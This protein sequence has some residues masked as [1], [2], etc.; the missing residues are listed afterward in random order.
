M[1]RSLLVPLDGSDLSEWSLPLATK[2]ARAT[3]AQLHLARVHERYEPEHLIGNSSFQWEGLDLEEYDG[4]HRI[5]ESEYLTTV[6]ERLDGDGVVVDARLLDGDPAERLA[7]YADE[8]HS[9]LIVITSHGR[10]GLRRA[11]LGSVTDAIIRTTH[12]PLLILHPGE[13][14]ALEAGNLEI[15]HI[16]VPLDGS[17][18]SE[19]VLGPARDLARAA[20]AQITL[21]HVISDPAVFGPRIMTFRPDRVGAELDRVLSYLEDLAEELRDAGVDTTVYANKGNRPAS[22]IAHMARELDAD[23]IALA[24][25]GYGG[26]KRTV[27]G[28]VTDKLL[29]TTHVPLLVVRPPITA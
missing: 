10:S 11:W 22:A 5:H 25:H 6:T 16:V 26:M 18:A 1:L 8:V 15:R 9:D 29:R 14:R 13:K 19:A 12:R 24:T 27:L 4:R 28:S 23:V 2:V 3:G 21:L 7:G 20:G 17:T